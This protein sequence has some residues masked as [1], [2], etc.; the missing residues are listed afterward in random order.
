MGM[1]NRKDAGPPRAGQPAQPHVIGA[2]CMLEGLF[3][4]SG[5]TII[6]A[7]L[8]GKVECDGLLIIEAG[9]KLDGAVSARE[10][11]VRGD[12]EGDV[13]ANVSID[14]WP[15]ARLAGTVFA[16]SISVQDGARVNASLLVAKERPVAHINR[17]EASTNVTQLPTAQGAP[18]QAVVPAPR[19]M[20]VKAAS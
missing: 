9:G 13:S 5:T 11:V 15:G 6:A 14:V 8:K 2:G 1:F 19:Q 18:A 10:I 17:I 3:S 4:F 7:T 16:P 20:F 12:L